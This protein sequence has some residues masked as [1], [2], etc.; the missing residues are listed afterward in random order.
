[1]NTTPRLFVGQ[2]MLAGIVL[3]LGAGIQGVLLP[4][5]ATLDGFPIAVIGLLGTAY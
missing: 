4:Y 2:L 5:R 1:M 3:Q